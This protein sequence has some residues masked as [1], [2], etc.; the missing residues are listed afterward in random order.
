MK[1]KTLTR[2]PAV[3]LITIDPY[4]SVWSSSDA[5]YDDYTI[6]W[7]GLPN[8][9]TGML[10]I[11]ETPWR[12]MGLTLPEKSVNGRKYEPTGMTQKSLDISPLSTTY[13]FEAM[14]V[15]LEV[16]FTSPLVLSDIMLCSKPVSYVDFTV[17]TIDQKRHDLK[18]YFDVTAQLCTFDNTQE[19]LCGRKNVGGN[20]CG[21]IG[22]LEQDV[23]GKTGDG[24]KIDWG[25]L[26]LVSS[27]NSSILF[28]DETVRQDFI[29]HKKLGQADMPKTMDNHLAVMASVCDL[30][31]NNTHTI[32]IAYDDLYSV[33]YFGEK[34]LPYWRKCGLGF[35]EM[36]LE[37]LNQHQA[38]MDQCEKFDNEL[39]D[40]AKSVSP[41]YAEILALAYRQTIAAHKLVLNK[42]GEALFLSKECF[43]NGCIGTVDISYPSIPLFLMYDCE[44][45]KG[46]MRPIFEYARMDEW[47][48]SFAPHD[49]GQYPKANGQ[50]YG[51]NE[52]EFQ[53]PVEECGNMLIMAMTICKYEGNT[54]FAEENWDLLTLWAEYLNEQGFDPGEQLCT[55]D[56]AGH[57]AHNTNLS[58]KAIVALACYGKMCDL[59]GIHDGAAYTEQAKEMAKKWVSRAAEQDHTRLAFETENSWSLKYNMVWDH[60]L[61]LDL[62][63]QEIKEAE[64][65]Y[66]IKMQ[67]KYGV[68][69]DNRK[70]YTKVDWILWAATLT[71]AEDKFAKMVEPIIAYLNETPNRVPFSDW[72]STTDRSQIEFQNRSVLGGLF[73]KLL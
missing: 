29:Q 34:L 70:V 63:S 39:M 54:K 11:D 26:K 16:K 66:Y 41:E 18:L 35:D 22:T 20:S 4:F 50:V 68:P 7:T 73:I 49:V 71:K 58:V 31:E 40:R 42:N 28:S 13:V 45:V 43:S 12:F 1:S 37:A 15:E 10:M 65:D 46:M 2:P 72:Y 53:M 19:I 67:N 36:M 33:E 64:V 8:A 57:L 56:F 27:G 51:N 47:I 21:Y 48:F 44:F 52:L 61:S 59:I 14:G 23:L 25:Y 24:I 62:F 3:P 9:M 60:L 5:L 32:A 69:L 6:H 30:Y 17:R 38:I 55:D